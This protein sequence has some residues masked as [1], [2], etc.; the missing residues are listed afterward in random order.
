MKQ[1]LNIVYL[2][3]LLIAFAGC[4]KEQS[5]IVSSPDGSIQL[6]AEIEDGKIYYSIS[7]HSLRIIDKSQLGFVFKEGNFDRNFRLDEVQYGSFSET[8]EQPWGEELTADN[9]YNQMTVCLEE[10]DGLKRKLSVIFRAFDDGIG[11]R[12]HFPE[13]ENLAEFIILDEL[14]EFAVSKEGKA[15]SIPAYHTE[16][17]EGLYKAS[18]ISSL[19]TVCT[20]LTI[21]LGDS[22][23][24]SIHEANLKDYAAM[25][26]TPMGKTSR[27]KADLTPWSTGEKVFAKAPFSTPWRTIIL[28]DKPGDLIVSR[29]MLNLN[30]P[31]EIEDISWI[32]PGR[33]IGI[34][35]GMHME[36]YT[37]GQGPKHGATTKN[38]KLY[39]D[40]AAKHGFSG[41]LV[42]GWNYGWDGSWSQHGDQFSFTKPYPDFNLDELSKYATIKNTHLIGHHETGGATIN[43]EAQLDSAFSLYQKYGINVVK[44]GYV[45]PLLDKKE[46]HS[47]Q[48]GVRHF[49]K[50]IETAAKYRIMI[51][52]HEPVMP[53]GL[54]RTYPNLMTQEGVRGQEYDAW[55]ADG[56][57]PPEHTTIIPFT[58]GLA[59]PMDFTPGTF[60]FDNPVFPNTRVQ[61]T[62]A[63][64]LALN[65]I[66]FSPLQMASDMIENYE[67]RPEFSFITSCPSN[68]SKTVVPEAKI[69]EYVT[70]ARKD[71]STEN[72]FVGSITNAKER[73]LN[74]PL[75][76]LDEGA[77]YKA[78]IY[79]DAPDTHYKTNPYPVSIEEAEVTSQM[80]LNIR[81]AAGGGTA[82]MLIKQ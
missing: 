59:G 26:L 53:T 78:I 68:W 7:R 31:N 69:G 56:G 21:E 43:Y 22:L 44:T 35:W 46:R 63:K 37:W 9:T 1:L 16:Y 8:W 75:S 48:Y 42:E 4:G 29:L 28:A 65:V 12:Y 47:S 72:W 18:D 66:I 67:N 2:L 34:W 39:L 70:I 38:T 14:T 27:L 62:I 25:N 80:Q 45:N 13:Q 82:I 33:Y 24:I 60:N 5:Y 76:F 40:F 58:R 57:N 81:Q 74:L 3:F 19:D 50:V 64:Q 55:S 61:T 17:Y 36:K 6:S 49:R 73:M 54:Q 71:R 23:Y 79:K 77:K 30:E 15:W 51:D 32:Q 20:P 10:K 52:N 41:V 11:F